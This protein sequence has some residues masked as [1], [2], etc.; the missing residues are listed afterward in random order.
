MATLGRVAI[1]RPADRD[2]AGVEIDVRFAEP[3]QLA[4]AH[5]RVERE[6]A[7]QALRRGVVTRAD[8]RE[9]A[10]AL[11]PFGGLTA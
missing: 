6:A 5:A 11:Q 2:E 3:E 1:V 9:V 8:L 4:F 10:V 7:M